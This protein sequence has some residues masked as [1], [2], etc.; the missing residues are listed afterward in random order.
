MRRAKYKDGY[1]YKRYLKQELLDPQSSI[2]NR[3]EIINNFDKQIPGLLNTIIDEEDNSYIYRQEYCKQL[4]KKLYTEVDFSGLV[5]T[6]NYFQQKEFV[7]GDLNMK[8][9][10]WT[11]EGFKIIDYEPSLY[12][13][14]DGRMQFMTT[15]P[16]FSKQD[17][18]NGRISTVTDKIAFYY[19][20]LRINGNLS[21]R[22][23][24]ELSRTLDH[25]KEIGM[26]EKDFDLMNYKNILAIAFEK[27]N[28]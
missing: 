16:Y 11:K 24:V 8:N 27:G 4:K 19:F 5:E 13:I 7:H 21:N 12:Q 17:L 14:K 18:D 20:I 25:K 6:L 26:S 15:K 1:I 9:I 10:F 23:L 3:I 22:R 2:E 28:N